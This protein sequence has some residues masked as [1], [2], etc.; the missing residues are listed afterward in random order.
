MR[1]ATWVVAVLL[2]A[3]SCA[4]PLAPDQASAAVPK[5]ASRESSS[6]QANFYADLAVGG[7]TYKHDTAGDGGSASGETDGG[8]AAL[9]LEGVSNRGIGGGLAIE[10]TGSDDKLLENVGSPDAKGST[11]DL[12]AYFV[13]DPVR[14]DE[15]RLPLRIGPYVHRLEVKEDSTSSKIDWNGVGLRLEAAPE[16]W[17]LRRD[18]FSLGLAGS[19]SIGV[20]ATRI[21]ADLPGLSDSFNGDGATFGAGLGVAAMFVNHVTTQLGYVY[22]VTHESESD[23]SN[24]FVIN[25]ATQ[26]FRGVVL[27]LGVRF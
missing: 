22:R 8:F 9:R 19:V 4:A 25:E 27:Q 26:S 17:L 7:G 23:P 1:P 16:W 14:S 24:G 3:P 20:H 10:G 5:T 15:F 12:F 21:D 13:G 6:R 11:G 2:V 18:T